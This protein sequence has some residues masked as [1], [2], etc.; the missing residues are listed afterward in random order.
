LKSEFSGKHFFGLRPLAAPHVAVP[1]TRHRNNCDTASQQLRCAF[2]GG[3]EVSRCVLK[4]AAFQ[5]ENVRLWRS[6]PCLSHLPLHSC[7]GLPVR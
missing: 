6:T 4:K 2:Q 1:A 5:R 3:G 7:W